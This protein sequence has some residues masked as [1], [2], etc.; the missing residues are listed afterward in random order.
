AAVPNLPIDL[1][2]I[3]GY[4][5]HQHDAV[6]GDGNRGHPGCVGDADLQLPCR[7]EINIVR[8]RSPNGNQFELRTALQDH[9]VQKSSCPHINDE[10]GVANT[11]DQF[12]D[13]AG[14]RVESPDIIAL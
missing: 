3:V 4:G 7:S 6:L 1:D 11:V 10:L 8:T 14:T 2:D 9:A 5:E 13:I 12:F